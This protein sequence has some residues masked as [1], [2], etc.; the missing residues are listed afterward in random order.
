MRYD[1]LTQLIARIQYLTPTTSGGVVFWF[2]V[3]AQHWLALRGRNSMA[4][5]RAEENCSCH[6]D[7][8]AEE[9][10]EGAR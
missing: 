6:G 5:S 4:E 3:T 2:L 9:A 10:Q 1:A 8:E 7:Q